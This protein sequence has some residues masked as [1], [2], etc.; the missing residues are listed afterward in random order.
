MTQPEVVRRVVR[1]PRHIGRITLLHRLGLAEYCRTTQQSCI[2]WCNGN[3]VSPY[4]ARPM[5]LSHGVY[6]RIAL[7]PGEHIANHIGTRC[8]ATACH[9]GVALSELCDRHALYMLGWYD[10]IID[11][12]IVPLRPD[13]EEEE[14]ALLQASVPPLP[15]TPWFINPIKECIIDT[16]S[17]MDRAENDVEDVTRDYVNTLEQEAPGGIVPRPG[18]DEQ[19]EHIQRIMEQLEE[20]GGIEVEEE[21]PVLYVNTW[22]LN[23]PVHRSCAQFRTVRIAGN[24]E[25][26]HQQF[27]RR[28]SDLLEDGQPVD[29]YV[30]DPQPPTTRMQPTCLPHLLLLQRTPEDERAAVITVVDSRDPA[31]SF[32]HSAHFLP[33]ITLKEHVIV[34]IDKVPACYPQL[35]ELQCMI[36][37]GDRQ[38]PEGLHIMTHHGISLL[39][40]IQDLT[41]MSA[42]AWDQE[43][44]E[45]LTL[46][47]RTGTGRTEPMRWNPNAPAF[48]PDVP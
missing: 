43:E 7:P 47:Q 34:A 12:P 19:P 8:V 18:L 37:H 35:S 3:V 27:L 36:W 5:E 24:F 17:P 20:H 26:W 41:F 31:A 13:A 29:F 30:V 15:S 25:A 10:T 46:M 44:D 6:I 2:L 45:G 32:Q 42:Q 4:N 40:I 48:R 28:W 16:E 39:T 21:G 23:H 33:R 1:L 22:F 38:L 9:Q 14:V 11:H